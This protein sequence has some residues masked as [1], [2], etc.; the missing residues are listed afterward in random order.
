MGRDNKG[1]RWKTDV[2]LEQ[3]RAPPIKLCSILYR[4]SK[5]PQHAAS[6]VHFCLYGLD[7]QPKLLLS[8]LANAVC[9][10]GSVPSQSFRRSKLGFSKLI[11]V[12]FCADSL[13]VVKLVCFYSKLDQVSQAWL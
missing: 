10:L 5:L 1:F 4:R 8:R 6:I 7:R 12:R 3:G 13:T 11:F 2:Q 9:E